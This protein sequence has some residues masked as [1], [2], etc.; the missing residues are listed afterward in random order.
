MEYVEPFKETKRHTYVH[1]YLFDTVMP[2]IKPN[3]WKVLCYI[4]RKTFGWEDGEGGRK[5]T[6][7]L[8]YS[9]LRKGT[10]IASDMT[11]HSALKE[12]L[13]YALIKCEKGKQRDAHTYGLNLDYRSPSTEI[14]VLKKSRTTEIVEPIATETVVVSTTETVDTKE[15]SKKSSKKNGGGIDPAPP[16]TLL[17]APDIA[18]AAL[19]DLETAKQQKAIEVQHHETAILAAFNTMNEQIKHGQRYKPITGTLKLAKS[20]SARGETVD[21]MR[22]AWATCNANADNPMGAFMKWIQEGYLPPQREGHESKV[23]DGVIVVWVEG[24]GWVSTGRKAT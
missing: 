20:L 8:S 23:V 6:D 22:E 10:G 4:V 7:Q 3:A 2:K 17:S 5:Q 16:A 12:L 1:N 14:V 11:L 18:A 21:T 9:Q 13:S 15:S 19:K 24:Q